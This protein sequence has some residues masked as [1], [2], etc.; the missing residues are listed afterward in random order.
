MYLHLTV[1]RYI[2]TY[3]LLLYFTHRTLAQIKENLDSKSK[4]PSVKTIVA[5][6]LVKETADLKK[7]GKNDKEPIDLISKDDI[8]LVKSFSKE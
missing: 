8:S 3:S 4:P 5:C 1:C 7:K 6:F 2:R